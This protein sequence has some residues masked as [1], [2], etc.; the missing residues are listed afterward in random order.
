MKALHERTQNLQAESVAADLAARI[1][2]I[3]GS[4]ALHSC[5]GTRHRPAPGRV[6]PRRRLGEYLARFSGDA[7]V[8]RRDSVHAARADTGPGAGGAVL[9]RLIRL[10][11]FSP[12]RLPRLGVLLA[13]LRKPRLRLI[14]A[15]YRAVSASCPDGLQP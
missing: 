7:G 3:F 5:K 9:G 10:D 13:R 11:P 12:A 6:V 2:G 4:G 14:G 8:L 15:Q 1:A